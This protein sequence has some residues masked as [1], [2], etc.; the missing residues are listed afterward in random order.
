MSALR[1]LVAS[2][3]YKHIRFY[4]TSENPGKILHLKTLPNELGNNVLKAFAATPATSVSSCDSYEIYPDDTSYIATRCQEWAGYPGHWNFG[5][6]HRL[7]GAPI[8]IPHTS[9]FFVPFEP[10]IHIGCDIGENVKNGKWE[11]FIR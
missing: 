10:H 7:Y 6:P 9:H 4:C 3:L 8:F 5:S 11:V 1:S 2:G